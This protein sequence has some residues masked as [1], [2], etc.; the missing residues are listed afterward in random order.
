LHPCKIFTKD[1]N[2]LF[3][4]QKPLNHLKANLTGIQW[5]TIYRLGS[6]NFLISKMTL[7][8][9]IPI[10][11]YFQLCLVFV[12][13]LGFSEYYPRSWCIQVICPS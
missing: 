7:F 12:G 4:M 6:I 9:N 11:S 2:K 1:I 5:T 13:H 3:N 8:I 10:G